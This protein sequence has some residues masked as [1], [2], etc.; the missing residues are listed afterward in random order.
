MRIEAALL[1]GGESRRMGVDKADISIEGTPQAVRIAN[2]LIAA[3]YGVTVLGRQPIAG[4][5][6]LP[7]EEP[8]GGPL[9]ALSWFVPS[10]EAVFVCSC[11]MP[12][13]DAEI[14][15]VLHEAIGE[16]QACVPV[17][18]GRLQPLCALYRS[19]ALAAIHVARAEGKRLMRWLSLIDCTEMSESALADRGFDVRSIWSANTPQEFESVIRAENPK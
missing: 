8:L 19:E 11:D 5:A 17:L 12:R 16:H 15:R 10:A 14:V 9:V 3:G 2:S 6:F 18:S 7:D 1:T 13:F 4:C